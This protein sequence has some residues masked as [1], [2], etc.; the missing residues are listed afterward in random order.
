MMVGMLEF[1]FKTSDGVNHARTPSVDYFTISLID[2]HTPVATVVDLP[3]IIYKNRDLVLKIRVTDD[4][5]VDWVDLVYTMPDGELLR[6][7]NIDPDEDGVYTFTIEKVSSLG[8]VEYWF[9]YSD[10]YNDGA[11]TDDNGNPFRAEI[12]YNP[13][14]MA[15][16][17]GLILLAVIAVFV[18]AIVKK[19]KT[20]HVLQDEQPPPQQLN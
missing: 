16:F 9:E 12:K 2:I 20:Q 14:F 1:Y 5:K 18:I 8:V 15:L 7:R 10:G 6:M 19:F 3:D 13:Y 11:L 4:V 17:V